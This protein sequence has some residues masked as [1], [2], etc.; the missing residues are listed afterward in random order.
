MTL[1]GSTFKFN[2]SERRGVCVQLHAEAPAHWSQSGTSR[3]PSLCRARPL[4]SSRACA[5]GSTSRM[6][7]LLVAWGRRGE[8]VMEGARQRGRSGSPRTRDR[9]WFLLVPPHQLCRT[10][11][12]HPVPQGTRWAP[13]PTPHPPRR[14]SLAGARQTPG[15]SSSPCKWAQSKGMPTCLAIAHGCCAKL[16]CVLYQKPT[17][18]KATPEGG[19]RGGN[20]G[21]SRE[22]LGPTTHQQ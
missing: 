8:G 12:A 5:S 17:R 22:A 16:P 20:L 14:P 6:L 2:Q 3:S 19:T 13:A 1:G 4:I 7:F 21:K 11:H 15:P 18:N 9:Q 10:V